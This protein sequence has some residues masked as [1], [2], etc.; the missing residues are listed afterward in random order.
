MSALWR[1]RQADLS[2]KPAWSTED[3]QVTRVK[4]KQGREP[5]DNDCF[6]AINF[7]LDILSPICVLQKEEKKAAQRSNSCEHIIFK[8]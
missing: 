7:V 8:F 5:W 6:P 3:N 1:H 4:I 2:L